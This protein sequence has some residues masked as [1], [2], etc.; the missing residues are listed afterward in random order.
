MGKTYSHTVSYRDW[1]LCQLWGLRRYKKVT[2]RYL[3]TRV[4][5][6]LPCHNFY[7]LFKEPFLWNEHPTSR[8]GSQSAI[9]LR[10]SAL[11]FKGLFISPFNLAW[12]G[13]VSSFRLPSCFF[14]R[15]LMTCR[16]FLKVWTALDPGKL[17]NK[18][19]CWDLAKRWLEFVCLVPPA[20]PGGIVCGCKTTHCMHSH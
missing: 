13:K 8:S 4:W 3:I 2:A 14:H 15:Q 6:H 11:T 19:R 7:S 20:G 10:P 1:L 16:S 9:A 17:S 12:K 5:W 18:W